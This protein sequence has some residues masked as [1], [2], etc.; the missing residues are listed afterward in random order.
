MPATF[1]DA[2]RLDFEEEHDV[3]LAR[4]YASGCRGRSLNADTMKNYYKTNIPVGKKGRRSAEQDFI[5][6]R[7]QQLVRK[8]DDHETSFK[9]LVEIKKRRL[10][11]R[12]PSTRTTSTRHSRTGPVALIGNP[13][14]RSLSVSYWYSEKQDYSVRARRYTVNGGVQ[15]MSRR[16]QYD[17]CWRSHRRPRHTKLLY[18]AGSTNHRQD[19]SR[20]TSPWS[21]SKNFRRCRQEPD[22]VL[23]LRDQYSFQR[24]QSF[25]KPEESRA[26]RWLAK[27]FDVRQMDGL[28][29]A[30]WGLHVHGRQ[31]GDNVSHGHYVL[32]VDISGGYDPAFVD[33]ACVER[34]SETQAHFHAFRW[35]SF[36]DRLHRIDSWGLYQGMREGHQG[37]YRLRRQDR[38]QD[39]HVILGAREGKRHPCEF[40]NQRPP[41]VT[42]IGQL[43]S[44]CCV[45]R[46]SSGQAGD[47][48]FRCIL[49]Q[50]RGLSGCIAI[51]ARLHPCVQSTLSAVLVYRNPTSSPT[52]STTKEM[53]FLTAWR[54]ESTDKAQ[55]PPW[56]M[57]QQSIRCRRQC[58]AT[59]IM[60]QLIGL[61]WCP[62]G[63]GTSMISWAT[64][65]RCYS[66]WS[67]ALTLRL[68]R[69]TSKKMRDEAMVN[70]RT[71]RQIVRRCQ[72]TSSTLSTRR[73]V[74]S[75]R[76]S[77][78]RPLMDGRR[79][80]PMC[81]F[82]S[83][84]RL[85]LLRTHVSKHHTEKTQYVCSGTKQV[86]VVLSLY[87]C[88]TMQRPRRAT[89]GRSSPSECAQHHPASFERMQNS[90]RPSDPSDPGC[91][92]P[93]LR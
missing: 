78:T 21:S 6:N 77:Q 41:S 49:G 47:R 52:W 55:M 16:L 76:N 50:Q 67:Q 92:W 44:L 73:P 83:F 38:C 74:L 19:L 20:T 89:P 5:L 9:K 86:K 40:V 29:P 3:G 14:K 59:F 39:T 34:S 42:R 4:R 69:S 45:A 13:M 11:G 65:P 37:E 17:V 27:D 82:R 71:K 57:V 18:D 63:S 23:G 61:P 36:V 79:R 90:H 1:L 22:G 56:S 7:Y 46:G 54:W 80:C 70:L 43:H 93:S 91:S 24:R 2:I 84:T 62:T 87:D 25:L 85:R 58:C 30:P 51:T 68:L 26:H 88:T 72:M 33:R 64:N 28:Q 31:E 81:P 66:K 12:S 32:D 10:V 15:S 35:A 8:F 53:V 75:S 60:P 48:R